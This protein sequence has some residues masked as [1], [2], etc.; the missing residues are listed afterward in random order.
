M[1]FNGLTKQGT[2]WLSNFMVIAGV[3]GPALRELLKM[4]WLL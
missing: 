3:K 4:S 2:P 1:S